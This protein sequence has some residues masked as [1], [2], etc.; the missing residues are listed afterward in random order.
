MKA[1]IVRDAVQE[2]TPIGTIQKYQINLSL[3]ELRLQRQQYTAT[4]TRKVT[5]IN[6]TRT[7]KAII[8]RSERRKN[9]LQQKTGNLTISLSVITGRGSGDAE[10]AKSIFLL[11]SDII[12]SIVS[13]EKRTSCNGENLGR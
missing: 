3:H 11:L 2:R 8:N 1:Y 6:M 5:I 12:R 9:C 13:E 4:T 10:A 7:I